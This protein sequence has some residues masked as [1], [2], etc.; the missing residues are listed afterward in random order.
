[1]DD[2]FHKAQFWKWIYY[3]TRSA[4]IVFAVLTSAEALTTPLKGTQ[5]YF[6][7]LVTI[8]SAF[9]S[10]LK[11]GAKYRAFYIANDEYAQL[12]LNVSLLAPTDI[13]AANDAAK[14]Y[15]EINGRLSKMITPD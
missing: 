8:I 2:C 14:Q 3:G 6:A 5:P 4:L 13:N 10:W 12:E 7:L 9:D 15:A 1:M 11:P